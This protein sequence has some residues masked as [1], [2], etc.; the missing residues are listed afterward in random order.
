MNGQRVVG[1]EDDWTTRKSMRSL[2]LQLGYAVETAGTVAEG[3]DL[4]DPP[5][6]FLILDLMLPDG[7]GADLLRR[8]RSAR[9]PTRVAGTTGMTDPEQLEAVSELGP[10]GLLTKPV[11]VYDLCCALAGGKPGTHRTA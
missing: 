6:D 5:P 10:E 2:F 4:L 9:L 1:I 7:D 11:S 3:L 8:V